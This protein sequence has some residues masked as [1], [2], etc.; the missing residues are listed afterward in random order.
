MRKISLLLNNYFI[1]LG[2]FILIFILI[3]SI[4]FVD[5]LNFSTDQATSS[6]KVLDI[7]RNKKISLIG[8]PVSFSYQGKYIFHGGVSYYFQLIFLALGNF[9]PVISSYLYMIFSSIMIIPLFFGSKYL[10]NEKTAWLMVIVYSLLPLYIDYTRFLW[11]PNF[12]L[13]LLPLLILS[14]GLHKKFNKNIY[15]FTTSVLCGILLQLHYQFLPLLLSIF[16]YYFFIKRLSPIYVLIFLLGLSIGLFNM[17][18]FELRNHFYNVQTVFYILSHSSKGS[19]GV[20]SLKNFHYFLSI[21]LLGFLTLGTFTSKKL[22][23]L[24]FVILL[25]TDIVLYAPTPSHAF[26]TDKDWNYLAED[27][28]HKIITTQHIKNYNVAN[29]AYDTLASVQKY[30]L[31]KDHININFDNY[32]SNQYLFVVNKDN[33]YLKNPAYE[34]NTYTPSQLVSSWKINKSYNLYLL[35]KL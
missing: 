7:L 22:N 33:N 21:I 14:M 2:A 30:L 16:I 27:K 25:I 6:I 17:L 3:R 1:L 23:I 8:P 13:T 20:T 10:V 34:V 4:H 11:N 15:F 18:L 9:D 24:I 31:I 29:L 32:S 12:Q 26:G 28:I 5:F 35:K 19:I